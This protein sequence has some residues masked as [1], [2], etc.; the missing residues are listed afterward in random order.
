MENFKLELQPINEQATLTF[1][2]PE[3][4]PLQIVRIIEMGSVQE[5]LPTLAPVAYSG[6]FRDL[7][8][9]PVIPELPTL[10]PVALSNDYLDL[11]N[12]P[13]LPT[14]ADELGGVMAE[15]N[16][17]LF[18]QPESDK[19]QSIQEDATANS[20][21]AF[22]L[23]RANHTGTIEQDEVVGL[24]PMLDSKQPTEPGKGLSTNDLTDAR[25]ALI[26]AAYDATASL[27]QNKVDKQTGYG[28]S[29]NNY[30]DAEKTKL[31]GLAT[32]NDAAVRQRL[33]TAEGAIVVAQTTAQSA[34][35]GV[36]TLTP[37]VA[38]LKT[39]TA[40]LDTRVTAAATAADNAK[41]DAQDAL[42]GL[43]T[44]AGQVAQL[45]GAA[46]DLDTRL[47]T[48]EAKPAGTTNY[49]GAFGTLNAL[50]AGVLN[51]KPGDYADVDNAGGN[52]LRYCYDST[53]SV[54]VNGQPI[55][56]TYK[57]N[58]V[59][60]SLATAVRAAFGPS[61]ALD[62]NSVYE[63]TLRVV[64]QTSIT[65]AT[66]S[67][68]FADLP[69]SSFA[70]MEFRI[71]N[72]NASATNNKQQ[73]DRFGNSGLNAAGGTAVAAVN[74][75]AIV[76]GRIMVGGAVAQLIPQ[77]SATN[78]NGTVTVA[79]GHASLTVT[80]VDGLPTA[81]ASYGPELI[82]DVDT[83]NWTKTGGVTATGPNKISATNGG[84]MLFRNNF[85]EVGAVYTV[86]MDM[87]F[88]AGAQVRIA[89]AG[90]GA[91][92]AGV[93]NWAVVNGRLTGTFTATGVYFSLEARNATFTGTIEN[94]SL[95]KNL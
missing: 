37:Q 55:T 47:D 67:V 77:L 2:E 80:K 74:L 53:D 89:T 70:A 35:D 86:S 25:L 8:N 71:G 38:Q 95:R 56:T 87:T 23:D 81:G 84:N 40:S 21:D 63:F 93:I 11:R 42:D 58:D 49:R 54:W 78:T 50:I 61:V 85:L 34:S 5:P 48:L 76:T 14:R 88:T 62:M 60:L 92:D 51:P 91:T 45:N 22:L 39:T 43:A 26:E 72:S 29:Q 94:I 41:D 24:V 75:M 13:T 7:I 65:T 6:D 17:R 57:K 27:A 9:P 12:L 28:L 15:E 52:L 1:V 4:L 44:V 33:T 46:A 68:G 30:T 10:A 18:T 82:T 59:A 32:Y 19:L 69:P 83:A 90:V 20:P 31:A 79:A 3:E 66:L 73:T 64:F 36:G 16:K